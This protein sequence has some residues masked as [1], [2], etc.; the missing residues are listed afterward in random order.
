MSADETSSPGGKILLR[1]TS[2]EAAGAGLRVAG[3]SVV[4][5]NLKQLFSQ[6]RQ[7]VVASDGTCAL[8]RTLPPGIHIRA[9]AS[10]KDLDSLRA[11]LQAADE[12]GADEVRLGRDF[13]NVMRVTD[14]PSRRRAEDAV[15]AQLLRGDLGIVARHLNKPISF[16]I[17]RYLLIRLPVT[18]NQVSVAAALI[19]LC[20]AAL[21]ATGQRWWMIAGFF[22]AH[23]Q[24]VL[25]GCDGELA[26]VRFQQSKVGEWLDTFIDE[27]LNIA[28]FA[29]TGMGVWRQTGSTLALAV[30]LGAASIHVFYDGVALTELA[31]QGQGGELMRIRWWL[32]GGMYMKN[33]TG[34]KRG[35]LVVIV[36]GLVR[37][38]FF[39][40][41]FLIY[42]L[43]GVPFL[44]LAHAA[45]IAVGQMV[46]AVGQ[47]VWRLS[48]RS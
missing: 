33:R 14:E 32:A 44:A 16:R 30:G 21:V 12:A 17:T 27:G 35:D 36:H 31:R 26:R 23:A 45:I 25:D 38:D 48:R 13:A 10:A 37:R 18:P 46:L 7:V 2:A 15:F 8:P 4:E 1:A 3:L 42:A 20:G 40:F 28:L 9:I 22:L 34:K 19:G 41:A 43:A 11:E 5:R 39:V 24:S 6:K 29:A 47:V